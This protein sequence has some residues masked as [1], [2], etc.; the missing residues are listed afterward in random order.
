MKRLFVL[1]T[2]VWLASSSVHAEFPERNIENIYPWGPG[3]TMSASQ[4]IA[5]A[6]GQELGVNVSVVSTPGAAGTKAFLTALDKPAD[7]YTI[8]D[9]YVA[10]LVLQPMLGKAD[11]TY[12]DFTPLWA[13]TSNSFAIA[14]RKDD[15]RFADFRA[16]IA[17]AKDNP[18]K[19]RYSPGVTD[20]LPHMVAAKVMQTSDV[21]AQVVP[22]PEIDN[23]V[24]D[25]RG[26]ILDF[27]V[28]NPGVYT[29]NKDELRVLAV[30]SDLED[31]SKTYGGA[32]LVGSFDVDLGM[33]GLA[34]MGWNW[35]LIHKDTPADVAAKLQDS[36]GKAVAR[37]EV[38]QKL[39]D[40]GYVPLGYGPDKYK[41]V[42]APVA[43]DLKSGIDAIAWEKDKLKSTK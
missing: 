34:P 16:L 29:T 2:A 26:G 28:I 21:V 31:A 15:D 33:T 37:D 35:W 25:L 12:N 19:L 10:P 14:V 24:K 36:M 7:G 4:I 1:A 8:I 18:G 30:L 27:V 11:W 42:V 17:H 38:K 39:L 40:M 41:E 22:Y 6:M 3:A 23:A 5:D 43:A 13:A 20:A 9:G 32:P